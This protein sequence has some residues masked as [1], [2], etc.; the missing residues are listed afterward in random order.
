MMYAELFGTI[1]TALTAPKMIRNATTIK[2]AAI[3]SPYHVTFA[4]MKRT[5][6]AAALALLAT[7]AYGDTFSDIRSEITK[8]HDEAVKR[9]QD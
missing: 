3:S 1:T 7:F 5:T 4:P 2:T 6:I 9:L 8:R